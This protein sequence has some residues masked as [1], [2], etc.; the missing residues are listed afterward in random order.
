MI[1]PQHLHFLEVNSPGLQ[2]EKHIY[3]EMLKHFQCLLKFHLKS[4]HFTTSSFWH[5][6]HSIICDLMCQ[7][8]QV[9]L[10]ALPKH[11]VTDSCPTTEQMESCTGD[12]FVW[13]GCTTK[14]KKCKSTNYNKHSIS[15]TRCCIQHVVK[16]CTAEEACTAQTSSLSHA[17]VHVTEKSAR[18][19]PVSPAFIHSPF[20]FSVVSFVPI[21]VSPSGQGSIF[22]FCV[23]YYFT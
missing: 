20:C 13:H 19:F 11:I 7:H 5:C 22:S 14:V 16:G 12:C 2:E 1:R 18:A 3:K 4:V 9:A 10:V 15:R 23:K 21:F 8:N 17:S 6:N